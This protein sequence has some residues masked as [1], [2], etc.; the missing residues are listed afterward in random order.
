MRRL[1]ILDYLQNTIA[2]VSTTEEEQKKSP[3]KNITIRPNTEVSQTW[4][5]NQ[6]SNG[7]YKYEQERMEVDENKW[8]E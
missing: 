2:E 7:V 6:E 1:K 8:T 3:L 5:Q 4:L